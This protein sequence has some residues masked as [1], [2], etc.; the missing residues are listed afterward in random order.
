MHLEPLYRPI[1]KKAF[2][3]VWRHKFL[4][5]FGFFAALLGGSGEID[6]LIGSSRNVDWGTG[7]NNIFGQIFENKGIINFLSDLGERWSQV[8]AMGLVIIIIFILGFI[9][10]VWL[11]I[12][13]QIALIDSARRIS[14]GEETNG[15]IRHAVVKKYFWKILGVNILNK[16]VVYGLLFLLGLPFLVALYKNEN[17]LLTVVLMIVSYII[18]VPLAIIVSFIMRYASCYIILAEEE[19]L[20]AI[21]KGIDLFLKNWLISLEMAIVFFVVNILVGIIMS[22]TTLM[23]AFPFL[24]V[25][26]I[27]IDYGSGVGAWGTMVVGLV[28]ILGILAVFGAVIVSFIYSGWTLLFLKLNGGEQNFSRLVRWVAGVGTGVGRRKINV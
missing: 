14:R 22:V 7:F 19:L 20:S 24:M 4:W 8:P 12:F 16:V 2:L 1:L 26:E 25:T 13:S 18:L 17:T 15:K 9:I 27:F 6:I 23:L 28:I 11:F 21:K 5:F 3:I 10:L